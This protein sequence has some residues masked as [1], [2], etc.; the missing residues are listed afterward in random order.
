M[1][2]QDYLRMLRRE[3][4]KTLRSFCIEH[5][6]DVTYMSKVERGIEPLLPR[7]YHKFET[8]YCKNFERVIDCEEKYTEYI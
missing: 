5:D 7:L 2:F 8:I 4:G 3:S 1:L 6:I